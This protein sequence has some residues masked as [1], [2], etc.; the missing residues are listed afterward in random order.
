M[1]DTRMYHD[2]LLALQDLRAFMPDWFTSLMLF[3][4]STP[5]YLLLPVALTVFVF[6]CVDKRS[7]EWM[8]LNI[9]AAEY[10]GHFMKDLIANPRPWVTDDRIIPEERALEDAAGYS[11]PSGHTACAAAGLGT[12]IAVVRKRMMTAILLTMISLVMFSRLYLGVHTLLDVVSGALL[13]VVV[14]SIN[15]YL[16]KVSYSSENRYVAVSA[17]I[18]IV[19]VAV[20]LAWMLITDDCDSMLKTGGFMV[21]TM[22]GRVIEHRGIGYEVRRTTVLKN[23]GRLTIGLLTAGALLTVPYLL[24]GS[25]IGSAVGGFLASLGVFVITPIIIEAAGLNE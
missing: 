13:S 10:V 7:G 23:M 1:I 9:S 6:T 2:I 15:W 22:A 17:M 21:G 16:V 3:F 12:L 18:A 24:F 5:F 8:M 19:A 14:I 11:T 25:V 4:S 20:T